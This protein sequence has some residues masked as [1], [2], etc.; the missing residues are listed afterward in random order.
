MKTICSY[1]SILIAALLG[2][3]S[4]AQQHE[5]GLTLGA[6]TGTQ[7]S[8][9][10]G[11]LHF[12][13]GT[14]LQANYGYRF[15]HG[16]RVALLGEVHFLANPQRKIE[17]ASITATRDV[18]SLF[19]TPGIRIKFA[20]MARVSPY[21]VGGGGYAD[22]E[23]SLTTVDVRPNPAPRYTHRGVLDFGAGADF[24]VSRWLAFRA[25]FRDFYS[26]SPNFNIPTP[27]GQH[28]LVAGGGF[29]LKLGRS[30]Q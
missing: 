3:T 26:G 28:N 4:F 25:E 20:P 18:A 29:V 8:R 21:V 7:R 10:K 2:S 15:W 27:G 6:I 24:S 14:A 12:G 13:S 11:A 17:S 22:F 19:I 1:R 30:E 16:R 5:I 9:E 23:Q